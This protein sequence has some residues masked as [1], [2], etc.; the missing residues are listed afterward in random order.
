MHALVNIQTPKIVCLTAAACLVATIA[1]RGIEGALVE[2]VRA[3]AASA[4]VWSGVYTE[5]QAMRGTTV[6]KERCLSCHGE[7][8]DGGIGPALAGEDFLADWDGRSAGDLFQRTRLTMP[9]DDPGKLT[10]PE[11]AE[12]L[13]Y[14]FSINKFPSGDTEL[15]SDRDLLKQIRIQPKK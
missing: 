3:Q 2:P 4:T 9:A 12:V 10:A 7:K 13:A 11:T 8:L 14:I 1:I 5:A 15:A 6:Y